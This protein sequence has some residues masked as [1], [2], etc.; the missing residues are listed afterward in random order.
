MASLLA[1]LTKR[2]I[3]A[4]KAGSYSSLPLDWVIENYGIPAAKVLAKKGED[5]F[6]RYISKMPRSR[7]LSRYTP[8]KKYTTS[9][10]RAS[11]SIPASVT[12]SSLM[13]GIVDRK[14]ATTSLNSSSLTSHVLTATQ[15][16]NV[17]QGTLM[18]ERVGRE[19]RASTVS[20]NA[21]ARNLS[22]TKTLYLRMLCLQDKKP[23]VGG[24]AQNLFK[25]RTNENLPIDF[26]VTNSMDT[27]RSP[28]NKDRFMVLS[29]RKFR[30]SPNL[31][32]N[33]GANGR[34]IKYTVPINKRFNYL[35]ETTISAVEKI[36]PNVF[37]IY[38]IE[39]DDSSALASAA[40][41]ACDIYQYFT[42]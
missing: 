12:R 3:L 18:G 42:G 6:Y 30:L 19:I 33:A 36:N 13:V 17:A 26:G 11:T 4:F 39:T 29:D 16:Y 32:E 20:I 14:V 8:A 23:Q 2:E 31:A 25:S 27:I 41:V 24:V 37:F 7:N 15:L 38:W 10:Y 34:I 22:N 21:F 40:N 5:S 35:T 28:I 9:K 1:G